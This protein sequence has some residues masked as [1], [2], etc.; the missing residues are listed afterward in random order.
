MPRQTGAASSYATVTH[1]STTLCFLPNL[2][3]GDC[4]SVDNEQA[5]TVR[6]QPLLGC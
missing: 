1:G 3:E 6:S 2:H 4:Y 5:G